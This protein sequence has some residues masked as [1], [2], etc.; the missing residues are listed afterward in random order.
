MTLAGNRVL[1][2]VDDGYEE[3][4]F[5]YP[6][7]RLAEEG[8]VV[9]VAAA[10]K[11]TY[12]GKYGYPVKA[13]L[14]YAEIDPSAYDA[15]VIPGG[16]APDRI[17]RHPT[18]LAVVR[19]MARSRK[20]VAAVCHGPHVLISAGVLRGVRATSFSS[21]KDDVV[22]AGAQYADEP[23]VVDGNIITSRKPADLPAFARAIV[24][25]LGGE[26]PNS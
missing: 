21:I 19:D 14:A 25:A 1:V 2:F 24:A 18:A 4:E 9:S 16:R 6:R 20:V 7:L 5:W 26:R 12:H 22:N 8:A 17:R 10:E 15:V 13:D 23:V 11:T 3:L